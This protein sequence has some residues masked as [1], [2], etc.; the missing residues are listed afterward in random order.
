[1]GPLVCALVV[2]GPE[3]VELL[4]TCFA[5][6][7][8]A[9]ASPQEPQS[10]EPRENVWRKEEFPLIKENQVRDN[11]EKFDTHK[12]TGPDGM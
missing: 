11:L 10:L 7:S 3:K 2:E 6:V 9:K 8:I 12:F 4:T 1:M 5:S